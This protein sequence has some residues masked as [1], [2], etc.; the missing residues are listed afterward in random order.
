MLGKTKPDSRSGIMSFASSSAALA[1]P[2]IDD[3]R[4]LIAY[5]MYIAASGITILCRARN[6][7]LNLNC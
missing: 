6:E 5:S 7:T 2:I 3:V 1:R 4:R